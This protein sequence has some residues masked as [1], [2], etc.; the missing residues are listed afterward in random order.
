MGDEGTSGPTHSAGTRR[1]EDIKDADG[2]EPGREDTGTTGANR[3]SGE[4]TA[5]DST[6]IN[7][8]S[9]ESDTESPN[10]PPA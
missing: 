2:K 8:E 7:P 3:P 10:M 1:G 4:S 6:G 5:R 9:V